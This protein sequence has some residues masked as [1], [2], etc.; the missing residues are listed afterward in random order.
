MCTNASPKWRKQYVDITENPVLTGID[1]DDEDY[2]E[3]IVEVAN[4]QAVISQVQAALKS[5]DT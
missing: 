5:L 1:L 2:H 3:L 4:P